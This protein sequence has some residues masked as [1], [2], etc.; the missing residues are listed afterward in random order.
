MSNKRII[1][2]L[3]LLFAGACNKATPPA[4]A[5]ATAAPQTP[6]VTI[7]NVVSQELSR[8]LRLPGELQPYQDVQL[9]PK[10]QGFISWIGVDR[11]SEVK[12]GQVLVRLTAPEFA[13]Q[14]GEAEAKTN[15]SAAQKLEAESRVAGIRAQRLEAEAKLAASTATY[16]RLK[17]ASATP[18]VISGNELENA[19]RT[20]EA[21]Q[22]R[23]QF[24]RESEKSLAAQVNAL[25]EGEKATRA[26]VKTVAVNQSYLQIAAPFAGTITERFLH[27]GALGGTTQPVLRLQQITRLRLVVAVP[28]TELAGVHKRTR[29]EFTV[30][31]FPGEIFA[32]AIARIGNA[33]D[34]KTRTMP[35]ELDVNNPAKKLAPGMF[36]QVNWPSSRPHPSL[37]VPLSAVATTTEKTFVIRI[38]DDV[39][40]WVDVKRGTSINKD[41]KDLVEIFGDL[42]EGDSIAVRGTDEL[43]AGTKVNPKPPAK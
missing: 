37:F 16:N 30:P 32:G 24:Y 38:K 6:T 23:V 33:L 5:A 29:V 27:P 17:A 13:A 11:G 10:V 18:G 9:Y 39:A 8:N 36:P 2:L 41:G 3:L 35:V 20:M 19:Q 22:A 7:T 14:R 15:V 4:P 43:R 26:S 34:P 40:E 1:V 25:G 31:A 28:E 42:S 12:A 21:E